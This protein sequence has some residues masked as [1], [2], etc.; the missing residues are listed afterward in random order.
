MNKKNFNRVCI[1]G[2]VYNLF[3]YLLISSK[4][5]FNKT[6][7]FIV[8]SG[9][10]ESI[11]NKIKNK[12][13]IPNFSLTN[14]EKKWAIIKCNIL[15]K[16]YYPF[17]DRSKIYAQ[18]HLPVTPYII[19]NRDYVFI[20]DGPNIFSITQPKPI[21][22]YSVRYLKERNLWQYMK[23]RFISKSIGGIIANNELCKEVIVTTP[24]Y[25]SYL[26]G[27]KFTQI[28][29]KELWKESSDEK[30]ENIKRIFNISERDIAILKQRKN[31]LFTQPFADDGELVESEQY[32]LYKDALS[33]YRYEDVIIKVHPRDTFDYKKYFPDCLLFSKPVPFQ[34]LDLFDVHFQTAITICSTAV[35][36]IS[37]DIKIDWIGASVHSNI[38]NSYGNVIPD[39]IRSKII[40]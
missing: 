10:P 34:L 22:K 25:V 39:E 15:S 33:K 32:Q 9:I 23:D 6:F 7:F 20:E 24:D 19:G 31:I 3:L 12:K 27:K 17:L 2:T 14:H 30:K 26:N 4:E 40:N 13:Y 8:G 37:Y 18:D 29:I 5:E 36:A 11:G 38:L 28:D 1:T 16:L 21:W 35:T